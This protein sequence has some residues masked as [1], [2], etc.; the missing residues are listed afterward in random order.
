MV[1]RQKE[2]E[3]K[4]HLL[5]QEKRQTKA[6]KP[7]V[8]CQLTAKQMIVWNGAMAEHP[9]LGISCQPGREPI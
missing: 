7:P 3:I 4:K 5:G 8:K 2:V 6:K 9:R 1:S